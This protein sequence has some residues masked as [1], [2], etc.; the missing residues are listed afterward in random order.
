MVQKAYIGRLMT[1]MVII[2]DFQSTF[3]LTWPY[4]L[5]V[6][7]LWEFLFSCTNLISSVQYTNKFQLIASDSFECKS[8]CKYKCAYQII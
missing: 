4:S 7:F 3:F 2:F 1:S 5:A 6:D 8:T